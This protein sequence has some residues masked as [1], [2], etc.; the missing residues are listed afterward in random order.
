MRLYTCC[1]HE[2][3]G[4]FQKALRF[5]HSHG[6]EPSMD[7]DGEAHFFEFTYPEDWS[8]Q[9]KI[10][11]RWEVGKRTSGMVMCRCGLWLDEDHEGRAM[12][13]DCRYCGNSVLLCENCLDMGLFDGCP[14][15]E[16]VEA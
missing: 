15:C 4:A 2:G 16:G 13:L 11:F 3:C 7:H 8:K 10:D 1:P 9:K 6:I 14:G 12:R 5:L